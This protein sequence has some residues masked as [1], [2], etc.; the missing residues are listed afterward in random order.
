MIPRRVPGLRFGLLGLAL[1]DILGP[2]AAKAQTLQELV[3]SCESIEPGLA[4]LCLHAGLTV[5]AAHKAIALAASGGASVPGSASTLGWR[6]KGSPR[7]AFSLKGLVARAPFPTL[8]R[9]GRTPAGKA[10]SN[11]PALHAS[12]TVGLFDGFSPAPTVGGFGSVDLVFS[13]QWISTP[14]SVGLT[15]KE[16]GWGFG[17]RV[18]ILRESFSLPGIS[19]SLVRRDVGSVS[20][21]GEASD[22]PFNAHS[23]LSVVSIRGIVGK[24]I[25]GLGFFAGAGWDRT[26]G[27]TNL[28]V[29]GTGG[30]GSMMS[31]G[32]LGFPNHN[33]QM[34]RRLIFAGGSM[35]FLA[36]QISL[37]G[38]I[39]EGIDEELPTLGTTGFDPGQRSQFVAAGVRLTF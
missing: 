20:L 2:R 22:E 4:S 10:H 33:L 13:G 8:G 39:A 6:M 9:D 1:L 24:D 7:I 23:D 11:L 31:D 29:H 12:V 17:A 27:R 38:G 15:G 25:G 32:G 26:D 34:D 3:V 36:F 35:T 28:S 14:T 18:G 16:L 30:P 5:R 37:E 21:H 19:L